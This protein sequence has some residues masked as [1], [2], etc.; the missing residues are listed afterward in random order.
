MA[1][2]VLSTNDARERRTATGVVLGTQ[3]AETT[4]AVDRTLVAAGRP[5]LPVDARALRG[6]VGRHAVARGVQVLGVVGPDIFW[7]GTGADDRV[8][9]HLQGGGAA[10]P[11]RTGQRLDFTGVITANA[12]G[13]A[14]AWGLTLAEGRGRFAAERMHVEVFGPKIRFR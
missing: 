3:H 6:L 1:A 12:P 7:V 10:R 8:L 4:R 14:A 5:L 9:V 13:S 2:A 11:I